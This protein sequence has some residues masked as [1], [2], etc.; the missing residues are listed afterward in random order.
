[1]ERLEMI[2]DKLMT[3]SWSRILLSQPFFTITIELQWSG[4]LSVFTKR[5]AVRS[6]Y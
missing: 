6:N 1:M 4:K 2:R 5:S 3:R